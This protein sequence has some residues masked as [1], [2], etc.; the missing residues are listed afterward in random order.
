MH[1]ECDAGKYGVNC[2]ETCSSHCPDQGDCD[3]Q[4]GSCGPCVGWI[5][6]EKCDLELGKAPIQISFF[7]I[8]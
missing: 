5:V 3:H 1:T 6:G 8:V 2:Q 4:D 7:S